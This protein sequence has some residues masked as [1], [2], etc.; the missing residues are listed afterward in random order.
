M[1]ASEFFQVL[2]IVAS[3]TTDAI[4][5]SSIADA[6]T[7]VADTAA[8]ERLIGRTNAAL[9]KRAHKT[10]TWFRSAEGK[11]IGE[12][13][14]LAKQV[15]RYGLSLDMEFFGEQ[16]RAR[17]MGVCMA[18]ID[19]LNMQK[20]VTCDWIIRYDDDDEYSCAWY[21]MA[22]CPPVDADEVVTGEWCAR[23]TPGQELHVLKKYGKLHTIDADY[24]VRASRP[25]LDLVRN[26]R[27]YGFLNERTSKRWLARHVRR[28]DMYAALRHS[29]LLTPR[30]GKD[31]LV[32]YVRK[33]DLYRAMRDARL[34]PTTD[35]AWVETHVS[36][37]DH[38]KALRL[39]ARP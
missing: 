29:G 37:R 36:A 14:H 39:L 13:V 17:R 11:N 32:K 6:T 25:G 20:G 28:A 18:M 27:Q 2:D 35:A 4:V 3:R 10:V 34:F 19:V 8:F 16:R 23:H 15:K 22:I 12:V 33:C 26:L 21:W 7:I 24:V 38:E 31:W 30:I 5:L 9:V 1:L